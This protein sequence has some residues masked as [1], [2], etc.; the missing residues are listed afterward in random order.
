M[1]R[2]LLGRAA[3]AV[4]VLWAAFTL[5]FGMLYL[6]PGNPVDIKVGGLEQAAADPAQVEKLRAQLGLDGPWWQQY[7]QA[8][9]R[10]LHGDF[11]TSIQTGAPVTKMILDALPSTLSIT[12]A[13]LAL[14]LVLGSG[15]ALTATYTR[16]RPIRR[17]LLSVPALTISFPPF[18][19][20]LMLIHLVAFQWRALPSIGNRG[21]SSIV[22]PAIT[23]ALPTSALIAQVLAKSLRSAMAAPYI[24]TPSHRSRSP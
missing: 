16:W 2:Y 15:I 14:A 21:F 19:V 6:L 18:W 4:F 20:G 9:W 12:S 24:D 5:S 22:L 10:A 17:M 13:G 3:A 7:G 11:G 1:V 23:I 8:L